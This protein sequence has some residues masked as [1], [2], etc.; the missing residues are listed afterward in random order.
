MK[1]IYDKALS[2]GTIASITASAI[3]ANTLNTGKKA[4]S[5]DTYPGKEFTSTG[6]LTAD[7]CFKSPAGGTDATITVEGSATGTGGWTAIGTGKFTLADMQAGPCQVA[8]SPNRFQ[9]LQVKISAI[10]GAFTA[11][12][13]AAAEAFLNTNEGK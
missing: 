5:A 11:A 1:L 7:V 2:F 12:S 9:Y 6:R 10:T 3:F 4:G 13:P 8:I